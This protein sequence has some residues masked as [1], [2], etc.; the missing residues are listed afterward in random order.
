MGKAFAK[1]GAAVA[2][3]FT[4]QAVV[5]FGRVCI[6]AASDVEEM[7]N[8]FN[9]VF[10]G[11]TEEV[12]EWAKD[13]ASAIGRNKNTI[14]GY[15]ADNQNMFVGMG[16]TRKAAA[17]LSQDLVT[18]ALDLASF[19]NLQEDQAVNALSKAL[20]G[21]SEAAKTL[22][23]VLNE[24]TL[25][26]AMNEMGIRGRFDALTESEKMEVRYQAILMQS[27]DAV[28]DCA[29]SVDSFKGS[30]IRLKSATDNLKESIGTKLLPV[31]TKIV[32]AL[33]DGAAF[34]AANL[35]SVIFV[36]EA[37]ATVMI[38]VLATKAITAVVAGFQT[39]AL[40]VGL[41][42]AANGTAAVSQGALTG[43]LT[44]SE[45]AVALL[46]GKITLATAAQA[47][48]NAVMLANPIGIVIA[49][50][51]ALGLGIAAIIKDQKNE[52][53]ELAGMAE[54]SEEAAAKMETLQNRLDELKK[55]M[56]EEPESF[57]QEYQAEW[58]QTT[59]ALEEATRQYEE[60]KAAEEAAAVAAEE[61]VDAFTA[62]TE[63]YSAR[64][65]ELMNK[66]QETYS[67]VLSDVQ[68]WF[69]PFEKAAVSVTTSID[70]I[71]AGMQSQIDF[72]QQYTDNLQ[73]LKDNGLGSLADAFQ[74]YGAEGSAYAQS[75]TEAL[76]KAGG[77]ST[78][79]GQKIINN[80]KATYAELENSQGNL[81]NTL[82]LANGEI[83]NELV[84]AADT[85]AEAIASYDKSTEAMTNAKKT[86]DGILSGITSKTPEISSAMSSLGSSMMNALNRSIGTATF[87]LTMNGVPGFATGL[88]Y[89]PYDEFPALLHKG[90]AVLTASEASAWRAGKESASRQTIA[91]EPE[92]KSNGSGVTI[93]QFIQAIA[94]TPV[95]LAAVTEAYFQNARWAMA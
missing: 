22:G 8:K 92:A 3:A 15:L 57:T 29:R 56:E 76:Q 39:A 53:K 32:S 89:V 13:F 4:V 85:Y 70:D 95:E 42:A 69:Q 49:A 9:V 62:A 19:N 90:E 81:A 47:A 16:M 45:V 82:T 30:Q 33:A 73:Y 18:L 37:L 93:N 91:A 1:I 41:Y 54:T 58:T 46:T 86:M 38:G 44:L 14:K 61:P 24:N 51:A 52:I 10:Q 71:M 43:A 25:Q 35:D 26:M 12:D 94:Q 20:M 59:L 80:L 55:M 28:G 88:D 31:V 87:T 78:E 84:T 74:A 48:W 27:T 68:G 34:I 75:V 66:F 79:E 36:V 21:E 23:A 65:T 17:G 63:A 67:Q 50:V 64:V 83:E 11:M 6:Q 7:E 5:N 72:N 2:G 77:A 60:L 40:Q